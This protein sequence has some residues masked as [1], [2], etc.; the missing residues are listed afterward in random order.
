MSFLMGESCMKRNIFIKYIL[1]TPIRN[2]VLS[3][4]IGASAFMLVSQVVEHSIIRNEINRVEHFYRSIGY[5]NHIGGIRTLYDE[6]SSGVEIF[7]QSPYIAFENRPTDYFASL[8]DFQNT[9]TFG[10]I[11]FCYVEN[12]HYGP[13]IADAYIFGELL[14]KR[15][16]IN[17]S[18]FGVALNFFVDYIE[19]GFP[20]HVSVGEEIIL[21]AMLPLEMESSFEDMVIGQRYFVKGTYYG[22]CWAIDF[23]PT[24][25]GAIFAGYH[26]HLKP[27]ASDELWYFPAP[28]GK[29][30]DMDLIGVTTEIKILTENQ[31][32]M[33][34]R[35][36]KDMTIVPWIM[37]GFYELTDGRLLMRED[38]LHRNHVAVI[39]FYFALDRGLS[40]GD[41]LS[42][43][44][45]N[46]PS[47]DMA[48]IPRYLHDFETY[49]TYELELEIVGLYWNGGI[50]MT[51][52]D[53]YIPESIIPSEF[54]RQEDNLFAHSYSFVLNSTRYEQAFLD[55]YQEQ[56]LE[57]GL[58]VNFFAHNAEM[59]WDIVNPIMQS[60]RIN[61]TLFGSIFILIMI[62][63]ST[64]IL[65]IW[66]RYFAI[67][68]ALGIPA[69][70]GFHHM[71]STFFFVF[72]LP[73]V[74]GAILGRQ[75]AIS[76]AYETMDSILGETPYVQ[77]GENFSMGDTV[78]LCFLLILASLIIFSVGAIIVARRPVLFLLQGR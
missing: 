18:Y 45:R 10:W 6:V 23:V 13:K 54:V 63:V 40:I 2:I 20:E 58:E 66:R 27:L 74:I 77:L 55:K 39:N 70:T 47:V 73:M 22:L 38:Y 71:L 52:R 31:R 44:L 51:S 61:V 64:L 25:V 41:N 8:K 67:L 4:L 17:D 12:P 24:G 43:T 3:I 11:P 26:L 28:M 34:L 57:I 14:S 21:Y 35:T 49:P 16:S 1:R 59:M 53:I 72:S 7:S 56:L 36:T 48:G 15:T 19:V 76:R 75:V 9:D 78:W 33:N 68:R 60:A 69:K 29:E 62:L 65:R 32:G 42:L 50:F 37:Y 5:L 30:L 46:I